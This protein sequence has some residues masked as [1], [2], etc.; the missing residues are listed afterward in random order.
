MR[1]PAKFVAVALL[2]AFWAVPGLALMQCRQA[3]SPSRTHCPHCARMQM[4][5]SGEAQLQSADAGSP[6]C[7]VLPSA[8]V[9]KPVS[10]TQTDNRLQ[11]V[12]RAAAV[13]MV[14]PVTMRRGKDLAVPD[15]TLHSRSQSVLCTFLI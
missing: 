14:T 9:P 3:V 5:E 11:V 1:I 15:R 13:E 2:L 6:C 8:P 7:R 12:A 4:A 10:A